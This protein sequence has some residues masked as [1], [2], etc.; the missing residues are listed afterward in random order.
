MPKANIGIH[1]GHAVHSLLSRPNYHN[2]AGTR[3]ALDLCEL[4]STLMEFFCEDFRVVKALRPVCS[5][6]IG[7]FQVFCHFYC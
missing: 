1:V 5:G 4:P 6:T 3:V 7:L 2:I